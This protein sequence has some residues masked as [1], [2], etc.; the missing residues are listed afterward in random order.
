[1]EKHHWKRTVLLFFKDSI[2]GKLFGLF[3]KGKFRCNNR[4]GQ[5]MPVMIFDN[6]SERDKFEQWFLDLNKEY[7]ESKR[8]IIKESAIMQHILAKEA[9]AGKP[10]AGVIDIAISFDLYRIW[11]NGINKSIDK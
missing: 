7:V 3:S 5:E 1:M 8:M 9:K 11:R 10:E 2:N 4:F 6:E